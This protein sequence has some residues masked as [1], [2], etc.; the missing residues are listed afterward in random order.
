M[1][2]KLIVLCC[3]FVALSSCYR[4]NKPDKPK[5]LIPKV[6]KRILEEK[7][8]PIYGQ[9][10]QI[11]EWIHVADNCSAIMEI[12]KGPTNEA[13]NISYNYE[14]SNLELVNMICNIMD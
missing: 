10:S 1:Q 6:I 7:P 12:L 8:I 13:Y 11:R 5:N 14:M 9:G 4:Y 3:I 2:K